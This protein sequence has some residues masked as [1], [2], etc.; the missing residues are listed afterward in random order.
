LAGGDLIAITAPYRIHTLPHSGMTKSASAWVEYNYRLLIPDPSSP[1][2][3]LLPDGIAMKPADKHFRC[4]ICQ[5]GFTRI[6][7]LK[8]HHLRHSGQKPYACIFCNEAF[9]RCD[10]LRDHYNDCAQRGDRKVPETGQR[11]RRRHACQ[12]C[13]SMKLRCDG[14]SPCGSCVKRNL[15]CN[16]ERTSRLGHSGLDEGSSPSTSEMY[17]QPLERGS[18]KFLL[19]RGTDSFTEG[20]RLPPNTVRG[21]E[22]DWHNQTGFQESTKGTFP[23]NIQDSRPQYNSGSIPPDPAALQFFQDTFL[24]F[25]NGPFG[26]VP[27]PMTDQYMGNIA[28]PTSMPTGQGPDLTIPSGQSIYEAERPFAIALHESI[29]A[30]ASNVLSSPDAHAEISTGLKFLLTSSRI[31]KFVT[32]Y[33]R[34]WQPS[35]AMIH[36]PSF[37]PETASLPL[38]ASLAFMGAMYSTDQKEVD[39]TKR[40][41]DFAELFIFSSP[42]Y[43]PDTEVAMVFSGVQRATDE[44]E[45]WLTFQDLQAGFIMTIVQYWAGNQASRSRVMETRFSEVIKQSRRLGLVKCRHLPHEQSAE[46]LWIQKECRIRTI[47]IISSLDSAFFFYQNHPCRLTHSEMECEF[48]CEEDLFRSEHPYS[49]PNFRFSRNLTMYEAF[50]S[51]FDG[52]SH[53]SQKPTPNIGHLNLTVF[54]LFILIHILFAFINTHMAL[55][56]LLKRHSQFTSVS[57]TP[58]DSSHETSPIPEESLLVSIRTALARWRDLWITRR[59][60]V[61]QDEWASMGFYKNGYNFWLVSQLLITKKDAVDV[62][63]QMEVNC[64]DKL[65]KFKVLLLDD[66]D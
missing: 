62:I 45:D 60:Q 64:E 5:R 56:G 1:A 15:D 4:T 9:A 47:A 41:L 46:R 51:L 14:Q 29:L 37:D 33:F 32:L 59:D 38:L 19:N 23:R 50:Q 55:V 40:L 58:T 28:Y 39:G 2:S 16:N 17:E 12:S 66:Q 27:R 34:Y 35:C 53:E 22:T 11:G 31:R 61:S 52:P 8:R 6:D 21:L 54:D 57:Q 7:H 25:F 42:I 13:T 3:K 30:R 18:I 65:E 24:D 10:N 36:I 20:F 48:P 63:M 26:D 49:E 43:S 44:A